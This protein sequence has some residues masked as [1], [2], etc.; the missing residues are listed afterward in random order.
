MLETLIVALLLLAVGAVSILGGYV[1]FRLLLPVIAFV[2][3]FG[4]GFSSIQA[5]FGDNVWSYASAFVT[6]VVIGLIFAVLSY[7]YYT[8]GVMIIMASL[9]AS[10]FAFLGEAVGLDANGLIVALLSLT[11]VIVG[12]LFVLKTGLQHSLIVTMTALFGVA[13]I[14]VGLSLLIGGVSMPELYKNGILGSIDSIV[15]SSWV[16]L[17]V[18]VGATIVASSVQRAVIAQGVLGNAYTIDEVK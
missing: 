8:V 3:G 6:A 7:F 11:G 1:L 4:V 18:L 5:L 9:V 13:S 12:G 14:M 15:D 16:W 10:L 2:T 17:F